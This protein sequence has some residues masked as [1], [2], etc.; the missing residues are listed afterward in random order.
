MRTI[1]II[2]LSC[3]TFSVHGEDSI[4]VK[5]HFIYGS[6]PKKEYSHVER[7]WFGGLKGG[8]VGLEVAKDSILNFGPKGSFHWVDKGDNRHS[9]FMITSIRHFWGLFGTP[10][11]DVQKLTINIPISASQKRM[12]DSLTKSYLANTPYD[13]AF[14]GMRCA[15]ASSEIL[16]RIGVL[17][18][19]LKGKGSKVEV[20]YPEILRTE[21]IIRARRNNWQMN[22]EK[23]TDRRKWEK[24]T[25]N[26]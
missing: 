11:P 24:D 1:L 13:Y 16:A 3:I 14:L 17:D 19:E 21:L 10:G 2:I 15:S 6:V 12:L 18:K 22:Y 25:E 4:Y 7:E 26:L 8:H 23:G 20:F 5:A 9:T